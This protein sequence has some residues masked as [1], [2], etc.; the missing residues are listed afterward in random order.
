MRH[1]RVSE[2]AE[3]KGG[4]PLT[5]D[6]NEAVDEGSKRTRPRGEAGY[7]DGE[8]DDGG[9]ERQLHDEVHHAPH[10]D[11]KSRGEVV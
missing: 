8:E 1:T 3:G 10:L 6:D 2:T 11:L 7:P 5:H 9:H 4:Y